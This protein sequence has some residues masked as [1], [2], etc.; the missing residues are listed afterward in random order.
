MTGKP[1]RDDYSA[2]ERWV[3]LAIR[4]AR[5]DKGWTQ[6]DLAAAM[7]MKGFGWRQSTVAMVEAGKR[8][9]G[10][11]EAAAVADLLGIDESASDW[12]RHDG[13]PH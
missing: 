4:R 8:R 9:L 2:R 1:R 6:E 11:Q 10:L 12:H 13:D 7:R 5:M 3:D